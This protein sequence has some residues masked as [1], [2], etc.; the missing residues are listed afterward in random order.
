MGQG[1][2]RIAVV[3]KSSNLFKNTSGT[4]IKVILTNS[5]GVC[6]SVDGDVDDDDEDVGDDVSDEEIYSRELIDGNI[7]VLECVKN[8]RWSTHLPISSSGKHYI[9]HCTKH[10]ICRTSVLLHVRSPQKSVICGC[11]LI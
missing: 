6:L 7:Y 5:S 8:V 10:L 3:V 4:V 11:I 2:I 1:Y 9:L